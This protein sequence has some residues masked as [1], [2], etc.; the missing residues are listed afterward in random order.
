MEA[1]LFDH[2]QGRRDQTPFPAMEA[3]RIP[4][5]VPPTVASTIPDY[6]GNPIKPGAFDLSVLQ[7]QVE[8]CY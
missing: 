6:G 5:T 4:R 8:R 1:T 3:T 2:D 7:F